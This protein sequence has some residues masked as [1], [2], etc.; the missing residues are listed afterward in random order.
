[1]NE[2]LVTDNAKVM[3]A[4]ARAEQAKQVALEA[5]QV[6]DI[7]RQEARKLQEELDHAARKARY[8]AEV[9]AKWQRVFPFLMELGATV[10]NA[11]AGEPVAVRAPEL[12]PAKPREWHVTWSVTPAA[13][14]LKGAYPNYVSAEFDLR[15]GTIK[16]YTCLNVAASHFKVLRGGGFNWPGIHKAIAERTQRV[17]VQTA[18]SNEHQADEAEFLS[19]VVAK[20]LASGCA[21][22][23]KS[24]SWAERPRNRYQSGTHHTA[25]VRGRLADNVRIT[26]T[27][28]TVELCVICKDEERDCTIDAFVKHGLVAH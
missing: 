16:V 8:E 1:M 23:T 13:K 3:E 20:L 22:V 7:A 2:Q 19:S 6:A 26:V 28:D 14:V 5:A 4:Q 25:S 18:R 17:C 12:D 9:L 24:A 21:D 10:M 11:T 15:A 27:P